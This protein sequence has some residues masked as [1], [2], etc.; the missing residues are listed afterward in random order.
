MKNKLLLGSLVTDEAVVLQTTQRGIKVALHPDCQDDISCQGCTQCATTKKITKIFVN[1]GPQHDFKIGD[2]IQVKH[3]VPAE[4]LSATCVF[5]LPVIFIIAT[6]TG[7]YF[8]QES[9]AES[10]LAVGTSL[11]AGILGFMLNALIEQM[12]RLFYPPQVIDGNSL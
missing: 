4:M 11:L 1:S 12:F 9:Q 6:I 2:K 3:F 5:G 8:F 10:G 7:W